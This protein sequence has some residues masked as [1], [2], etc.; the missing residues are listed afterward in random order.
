MILEVLFCLAIVSYWLAEGVSEGWT[1]NI[2]LKENIASVGIVLD[3]KKASQE[4]QS[5][6]F[7]EYFQVNL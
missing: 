7:E 4:L 5:R 3:S 1:W 2:P 6:D